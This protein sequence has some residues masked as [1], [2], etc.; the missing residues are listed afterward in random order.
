M[1]IECLKHAGKDLDYFAL[2]SIAFYASSHGVMY[3]MLRN[4][5]FYPKFHLNVTI[6]PVFKKKISLAAL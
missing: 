3:I 6:W 1:I 4:E 5:G 2:S